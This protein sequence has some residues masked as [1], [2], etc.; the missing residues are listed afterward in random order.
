MFAFD[1]YEMHGAVCNEGMRCCMAGIDDAEGARRGRGDDL[2]ENQVRL[3]IP[4]P[5]IILAND[6]SSWAGAVATIEYGGELDS[7]SRREC[8]ER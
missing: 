7:M 3:T 5:G 6:R 1:C 2:I 8:K 4:N